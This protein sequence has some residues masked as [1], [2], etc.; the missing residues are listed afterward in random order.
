MC[1]VPDMLVSYLSPVSLCDAILVARRG[2]RSASLVLLVLPASSLPTEF[3][4]HLPY[5]CAAVA[6]GLGCPL[7]HQGTLAV[8]KLTPRS[9]T[10]SGVP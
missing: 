1:Y 5:Y 2:S 9:P 6:P 10:L 4:S 8:S 3:T 7:A